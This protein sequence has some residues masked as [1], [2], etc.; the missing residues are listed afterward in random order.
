MTTWI[1]KEKK[2]GLR[3]YLKGI[4]VSATAATS[5]ILLASSPAL[6]TA[7]VTPKEDISLQKAIQIYPAISNARRQKAPRP[8][9]IHS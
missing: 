3:G 7:C 5:W 9:S 1:H 8:N 2:K 4:V 6:A